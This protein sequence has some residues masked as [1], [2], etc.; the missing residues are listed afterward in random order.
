[1]IKSDSAQIT[2]LKMPSLFMK[3]FLENALNGIF[4][5]GAQVWIYEK[6]SIELNMLHSLMRFLLM[7]LM[8]HI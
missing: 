7:E 6:L 3:L 1:M 5:F 4:L 8:M 2:Q